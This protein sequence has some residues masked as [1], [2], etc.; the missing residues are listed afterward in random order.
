ML[1]AMQNYQIFFYTAGIRNYGRLVM[2]I[3][4]DLVNRDEGPIDE[5]TAVLVEQTFKAERLIA[6][7]DQDR[8]QSAFEQN[9]H[10]RHN[11][12]TISGAGGD[13]TLKMYNVFKSLR[14]LAGDNDRIFVI[15]DDREDVWLQ[16]GKLPEN[17][18][19]VPGY[20]YHDQPGVTSRL[21][22]F[23]R[24]FFDIS[25]Y[26][27]FDLSLPC[28]LELLEKISSQFYR[29]FDKKKNN[30]TL[31]DIKYYIQRNLSSLF[32]DCPQKVSLRYFV[33]WV[34]VDKKHK[35][36]NDSLEEIEEDDK[37]PERYAVLPPYEAQLCEVH[38][39][40]MLRTYPETETEAPGE[41]VILLVPDIL[42]A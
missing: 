19:K 17:L 25:K 9:Q 34:D 18:L 41:D 20:F 39:L 5:K 8:F 16:A 2:S 1:H 31:T 28:F 30:E 26:A 21:T 13:A 33:R 27:D 10:D 15:L 3:I 23:S 42:N 7:D 35:P 12:Q 22:S 14:S 4:K 37:L 36:K 24:L 11:L 29:N 38:G 32:I 6:R 40:N